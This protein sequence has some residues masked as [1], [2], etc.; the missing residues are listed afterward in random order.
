MLAAEMTPWVKA[1]GLADVV[2]ALAPRLAARGHEVSVALPGYASIDRTGLDAPEPATIAVPW[3]DGTRPVAVTRARAGRVHL[4][5]VDDEDVAGRPLYDDGDRATEARRYGLFCASALAALAGRADVLHLHDK[6]A[7]L[8]VPLLAR[9][10]NRPA[11]LLTI[12]NLAFH[13][14]YAPDDLAPLQLSGEALST[15]HWYDGTLN[16]LRGAILGADAIV[17]VSPTY[18]REI[19]TAEHG[20][21]LHE[22]LARRTGV[23]TGILNGID[24]EVWSPRSD[25]HIA[26]RYSAGDLSGKARC[27]D[28]LRAELGLPDAG[29]PLIGLVARLTHQKGIDLLL[30]V[31]EDVLAL[32]DV[33]LLGTGEAW[34]EQ[35]LARVDDPRLSVTIGFDEPLAHRIEAG[36]DLFLMPSRFEPCGLNQLVSMAYGTLPVARRTGGLADTVVDADAEPETGFGFLFDAPEP[37]A[38]LEAVRR[39]V[40]AVTGPR[41]DELLRRAMAREVSWDAPAARYE[42]LMASLA[43]ARG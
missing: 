19:L 27:R 38:L 16:A 15:M 42:A 28:A 5:L 41:R 32:A 14:V 40:P 4:L 29:R 34:L 43:A 12:H 25:P 30:A 36:A 3:G 31:L 17:A 33:A 24:E 10:A 22:S 13:G 37:G 9:D 23:L 21:G 2:G 7:A 6:H 11:T 35:A 39:A 1:G 18:A 26:A 8:A 20:C